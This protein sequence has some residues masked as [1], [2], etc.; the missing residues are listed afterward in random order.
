M[1]SESVA[2]YKVK[3]K[4][5]KILIRHMYMSRFAPLGLWVTTNTCIHKATPPSQ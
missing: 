5:E 4:K 1:V 2:Y 3:K